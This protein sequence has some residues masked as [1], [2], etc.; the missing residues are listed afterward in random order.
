[1]KKVL[2]LQLVLTIISWFPFDS[3]ATFGLLGQSIPIG[4]TDSQHA[5]V[6]Q[7]YPTT[8]HIP[9]NLLRFYIEF[10]QPMREGD[11]LKHISLT[12]ESGEDITDVFFDNQYELWNQDFTKLTILIDPGRVKTGLV[13]HAKMGRAFEVGKEYTL[14]VDKNWKMISGR[15][16]GESFSKKFVGVPEIMEGIDYKEWDIQSPGTMD[17]SPLRIFFGK[18]LDHITTQD[19]IVVIDSNDKLVEGIK[20]LKEKESEL[21]F[22]PASTWKTDNYRLVINSRIED[23]VG[24]NLNGAFDH[25][26]G[27]LLNEKEGLDVVIHFSVN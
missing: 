21:W 22:Y 6:V 5:S 12:N 10:D 27:S 16:L 18:P 20:Q 3:R 1:M 11:F 17:E 15:I 23:I 14:T 24:N 26:S 13:A 4:S 7:I 19:F 2:F 25:K 9:V 8:K